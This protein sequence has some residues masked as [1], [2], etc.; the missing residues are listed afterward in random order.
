MYTGSKGVRTAAEWRARRRANS[1]RQQS[2]AAIEHRIATLKHQVA[3]RDTLVAGGQAYDSS[4]GAPPRHVPCSPPFSV[5]L[6]PQRMCES[7]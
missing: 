6:H 7:H 1:K 2:A 3:N 4:V 5:S